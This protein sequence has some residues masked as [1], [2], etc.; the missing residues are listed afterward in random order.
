M[1]RASV[2]ASVAYDAVTKRQRIVE[3]VWVNGTK[4][5][6]D[7]LF[8]G[9]S[10]VVFRYDGQS[11]TCKKSPLSEPWKDLGVPADAVLVSRNVIYSSKYFLTC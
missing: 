1:S 2:N 8:L 9:D 10:K 3:N 4:L 11:K 7:T 5:E 6:F